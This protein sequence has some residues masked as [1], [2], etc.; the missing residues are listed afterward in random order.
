[1]KRG[2]KHGHLPGDVSK[3]VKIAMC[4]RSDDIDPKRAKTYRDVIL[5]SERAVLKA[6]TQAEIRAEVE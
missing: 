3:R 2:I 6:R 1:M 5:M 4:E